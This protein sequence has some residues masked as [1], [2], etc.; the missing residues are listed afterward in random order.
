MHR[1]LIETLRE[2]QRFGFFGDREVEA[3]VEHSRAFVSALSGLPSGARIIDLG[4]GGGL[5]GFVVADARP[6]L[7]VTLLDRRQKRTD[8]LELAVRRLGWTHVD[9]RAA[10]VRSE[11]AAVAEG[12]TPAYDAVTARGFGPPEFTLRS[13]TGLCAPGAW[14]VISEPPD[15]DRW[16]PSLLEELGLSSVRL[17]P[18]RRF[19]RDQI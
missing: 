10:E 13:A 16:A 12:I 14:I 1:R 5:P 9:V 3:A 11:L 2:A 4:S 15:G 8:F 6:D 19:R 17:G 7:H 18:V